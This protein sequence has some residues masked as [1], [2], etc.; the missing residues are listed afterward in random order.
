MP[1]RNVM[2]RRQLGE[3]VYTPATNPCTGGAH[4]GKED[5]AAQWR[6]PGTGEWLCHACA[7]HTMAADLNRAL[8]KSIRPR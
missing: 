4:D 8:R 5:R 2:R 1:T 6:R 3:W 7:A